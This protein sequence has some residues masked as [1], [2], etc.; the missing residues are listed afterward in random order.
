MGYYNYDGK[1]LTVQFYNSNANASE[2][3]TEIFVIENDTM[4]SIKKY[5][6]TDGQIKSF[7]IKKRI[8]KN[9][10]VTKPDW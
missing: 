2:L 3:T 1:N 9:I 10:R 8:P 5:L 7:F 4:V 6:K